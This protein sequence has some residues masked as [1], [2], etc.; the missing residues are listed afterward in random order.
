VVRAIR[1]HLIKKVLDHLRGVKNDDRDRYVTW[2]EGFG[3][4]LKEGL[5]L[6]QDRNEKIFEL[7][8]AP[9]T[10]DAKALTTLDE[11]VER[12]PDEQ[13]VIYY[14][15]AQSLDNAR[16]SPHLEAFEDEGIEV[17]FFTDHVDEIWLQERAEYKGKKFQ[18]ITQGELDISKSKGK[19]DEDD[20]ASEAKSESAEQSD[21]SELLLAVRKTLQD[22]VKDVRTSTRLRSSPACLVTAEGDLTPQMERLM[23]ATGQEIPKTRRVLELNPSH[24]LIEKMAAML[25][26]DGSDPAIGNYARLLYGQAIL[27]EG[28]E[29]EDPA[30]FAK[31]V[32]DLMVQASSGQSASEA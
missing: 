31:L 4:V 2:W 12:A 24:P 30:D 10:H 29:L 8:L 21:V 22:Q 7:L 14:F 19:A 17:L 15:S 32:A 16:R 11:Y 23:R 6:S 5:L 26:S 3:P 18:S 25:T 20:G 9:S 13:E 1:K 28:G 27:A